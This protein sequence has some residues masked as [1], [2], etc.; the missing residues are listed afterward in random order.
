MDRHG[1]YRGIFNC[2]NSTC[3]LLARK[4]F[5]LKKAGYG[6]YRPS[7]CGSPF[8][9]GIAI[10]GL[11]QEPLMEMGSAVGLNFIGNPAE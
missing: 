7:C 4:T 11:F 8:C 9:R 10:L 3:Y 2:S 6:N 5:P 1:G